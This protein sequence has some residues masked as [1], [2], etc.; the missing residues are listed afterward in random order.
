VGKPLKHV[1]QIDLEKFGYPK[2]SVT[3]HV[4]PTRPVLQE[5]WKSVGTEQ[6]DQ[7]MIEKGLIVES[8]FTGEDDKPLPLSELPSDVAAVALHAFIAEILRREKAAAELAKQTAE[9]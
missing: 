8:S 9:E 7:L 4:N 5:F 3:L 1:L 2:E 6:I